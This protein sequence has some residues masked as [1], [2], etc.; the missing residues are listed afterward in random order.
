MGTEQ[1]TPD[2]RIRSE[3]ERRPTIF[4]DGASVIWTSE[5]SSGGRTDLPPGFCRVLALKPEATVF[6]KLL[7]VRKEPF[8]V[9]SVNDTVIVGQREVGHLPDGDVVVALG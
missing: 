7:H 3:Q 4:I 2:R 6:Q 8:G 5:R 9:G 1:W